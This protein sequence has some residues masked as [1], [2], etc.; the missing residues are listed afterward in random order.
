MYARHFGFSRPILTD[1]MAH[2]DAVFRSGATEEL[3][4]DIEFALTRRDSV[5]I[6]AGPSGTGKT[7]IANH[8]LRSISTRLAFACVT[9]PPLTG[10]ELL[11]QLLT[12]FGFEPAGTSRVE[13]RQLWRQF[14]S[15]MTA[16]DTRVCLLVESAEMLSLD[17]L[18]TLHQLTAADALVSAGANVVLTTTRPPEHLL[19]APELQ[20]FGQ[21]IRLRRR[22]AP[23]TETDILAYLDFKCRYG[24]AECTEVFAPDAARTLHE[25]SGGIVRVL[26][27][28]LETA[29]LTAA[30]ENRQEVT[31]EL[32]ERVAEQHFGLTRMAPAEV[33]KLLHE[34]TAEEGLDDFAN[35]EPDGIPTLTE[36][37]DAPPY[38]AYGLANH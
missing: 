7:T 9:H 25:L 24:D 37:V 8:A 38:P 6:L 10:Q 1:S 33:D 20:G 2:D 16:T 19:G 14:L 12:D 29:L 28:L 11:E 36:L 22:I 27:N 15:E 31:G 34:A 26:D 35:I 32:V 18:S 13:R 5:V 30:A 3:I 23:L 17:V 4:R 21:R